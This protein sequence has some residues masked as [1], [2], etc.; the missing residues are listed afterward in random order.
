MYSTPKG[1]AVSSDSE[2]KFLFTLVKPICEKLTDS[3]FY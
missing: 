2:N 3:V 1:N